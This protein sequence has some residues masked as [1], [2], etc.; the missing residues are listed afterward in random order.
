[1]CDEVT[2]LAFYV[3]EGHVLKHERNRIGRIS[4][5]FPFHVCT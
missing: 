4:K 1:M 5:V 3:A 2:E